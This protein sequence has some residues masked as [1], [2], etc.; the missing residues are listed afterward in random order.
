MSTAQRFADSV[1]RAHR[2]L[3]RRADDEQIRARVRALQRSP[4]FGDMPRRHLS[5]VAEAMHER[6]YNR[7]E[8]IYYEGDP[9]LGL[10]LVWEGRVRLSRQGEDGGNLEVAEVGESDIFGSLSV[11]EDLRRTETAQ[12]RADTV[13]LGLFRPDLAAVASRSP[14]AGASV[15]RAVARHIARKYARILD[16]LEEK[17][18]RA[19]TLEILSETVE[20]ETA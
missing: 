7:D 2:R 15:Y 16:A 17:C 14:S 11:F 20:D 19:Q 10:Y 8:Y 12:S 5:A 4:V 18:G 13:L 6:R 1:R 3:F 9:G